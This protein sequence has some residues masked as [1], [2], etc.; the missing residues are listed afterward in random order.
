[1][2]V[3]FS[4]RLEWQDGAWLLG[5]TAQRFAQYVHFVSH[6]HRPSDDWFHLPPGVEKWLR[7]CPRHA[8]PGDPA[9]AGGTLAAING[10][11]APWVRLPP[12]QA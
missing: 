10:T 5:V 4:T 8:E 1:V 2:D 7:L 9:L 6:S 3:G 11:T 12:P